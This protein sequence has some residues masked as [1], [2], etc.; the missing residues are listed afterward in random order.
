MTQETSLPTVLC[1]VLVQ[2][3]LQKIGNVS[4]S[5]FANRDWIDL[6]YFSKLG[7]VFVLGN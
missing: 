6:V 5:K 3:N 2:P 4:R 1:A 7:P